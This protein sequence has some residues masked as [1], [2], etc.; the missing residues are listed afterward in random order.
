MV[1]VKD[2]KQLLSSLK[3]K[4]NP[5][6]YVFCSVE[7]TPEGLRPLATFLEK[8]GTSL[9]CERSEADVF[10]LTYDVVMKLITM[11]VY[12]SLEAVGMTAAISKALT[13]VGISANVVAAYH[14]DHVFVPEDKAELAMATLGKFS[15]KA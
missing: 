6:L 12:S 13:E 4:L 15:A 10:N 3:P 11:E 1:A 2:L 9:I 8:E 5:N 14:H 7:K